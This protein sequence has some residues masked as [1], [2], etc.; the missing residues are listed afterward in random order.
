MSG[1]TTGTDH[2]FV[3]LRRFRFWSWREMNATRERCTSA[4]LP[5]A[6]L[7][8]AQPPA[9]KMARPP[10]IRHCPSCAAPC[11]T[12]IYLSEIR[13]KT[14]RPLKV[15]SDIKAGYVVGDPCEAVE[16]SRG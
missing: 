7:S 11:A 8:P 16:P 2:S 15:L 3:R 1:F 13:S 9:P 4:P 10:H 5:L 6:S 14:H 12:P